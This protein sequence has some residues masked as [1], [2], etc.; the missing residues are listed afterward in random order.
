[1]TW[2]NYSK[3]D[4]SKREGY[5]PFKNSRGKLGFC[6]GPAHSL[7]CFAKRLSKHLERGGSLGSTLL[8]AFIPISHK[9]AVDILSKLSLTL[10]QSKEYTIYIWKLSRLLL[11]IPYQ[12][13]QCC[14]H[15][16]CLMYLYY[17]KQQKRSSLLPL[18]KQCL[19]RSAFQDHNLPVNITLIWADVTA[20]WSLHLKRPLSGR[21]TALKTFSSVSDR[22][23]TTLP[24]RACN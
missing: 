2:Y 11:F 12:R 20:S 21:L 14:R 8:L 22:M 5:L 23:I 15:F 16:Y 3:V 19:I 17:T 24:T 9:S 7:V 4:V 18:N 10:Q 6:P 13:L 1:M